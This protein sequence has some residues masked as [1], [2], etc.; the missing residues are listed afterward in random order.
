MAKDIV[1]PTSLPGEINAATRTLHTTLNRQIT[2][3][4]PLALPPHASDP[5]LYTTGLLHYTPVF[6]TFESL[7]TDLC[8]ASSNDVVSPH[9]SYLLVNPYSSPTLF[10]SPPSGPLLTF[11]STLRP[12]GL[13]RSTRL[14]HDLSTL[15]GVSATEVDVLLTQYPG[16]LVRDFCLHIRRS[17]AAKPHVLV[18]YAWCF[19][20]AVFSGGRWIR[21]EL[22]KAG[23]EF[24]VHR[25]RDG[26]GTDTQGKEGK[27]QEE[28]SEEEMTQRKKS[29]WGLN[30]WY[31]AGEFDG[32]D[33][34]VEF[35]RRLAAAES[36]FTPSERV[37][38]IEE[39]KTIFKFSASLVEGLDEQLGTDMEKVKRLDTMSRL[40]AKAE[41][42][43]K[44]ETATEN[45]KQQD[46]LFQKAGDA[47]M[48]FRRPEVTGMLVAVGCLVCVL[49]LRLDP[50]SVFEGI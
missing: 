12:H 2:T 11:L 26:Q 27:G 8:L 32:E 36:L 18:A 50:V 41:E 7:W 42:K 24:W 48:W 39:A 17:V 31:F 6:L 25:V 37:D 30:F 14:K 44:R 45:R 40:R 29:D 5:A 21:G 46:N 49:L 47:V 1:L 23:E 28:Q 20:M 4:L 9:L 34:K 15:L 3:R 35:K 38:I 43:Q 19:Y 16:P 22:V 10:S 33:I 13:A